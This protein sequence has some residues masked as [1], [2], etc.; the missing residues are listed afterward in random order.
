[1][2]NLPR[3][4]LQNA[5]ALCF[6][7]PRQGLW[8]TLE[9]QAVAQLPHGHDGISFIHQTQPVLSHLLGVYTLIVRFVEAGNNNNPTWTPADKHWYWVTEYQRKWTDIENVLKTAALICSASDMERA[10]ASAGS[11]MTGDIIKCGFG[12]YFF[13][14]LLS[15]DVH[16]NIHEFF[17]DIEV[18]CRAVEQKCVDSRA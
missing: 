18:F 1:M 2:S 11:F 16:E 5:L 13:D 7:A 8:I 15:K 12:Y 3:N 10:K 17:N 9:K 4:A 14:R 6:Y